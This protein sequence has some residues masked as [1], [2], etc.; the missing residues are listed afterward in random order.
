MS[1]E[2]KNMKGTIK[3]YNARKGYGFI[4]GE[5]GKDVFVHRSAIPQGTF[6]NEGDKIEYEVEDTERGPNAK[7]VKKA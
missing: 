6:L 1:K 4:Q 2:E 3:W 5:D 7:N